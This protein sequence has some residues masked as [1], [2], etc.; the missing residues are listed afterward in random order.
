M[1]IVKERIKTGVVVPAAGFGSRMGAAIPKQFLELAGEPILLRTLR[2]FLN[3]PAT[4][5]VVVVLPPEHLRSSQAMLLFDPAC[6][7]KLIFAAGG[8]TRQQSVRNGLAALPAEIG[9]ILV[10]DGAR[11]LVTTDMID[12]CLKGI[13]QHGA[14]IAAV[15]V[16][17]T[18]KEI[19]GETV[20]RTVDRK[21]LWQAQTPQ[22]MKRHLLEQAYREAERSG[23]T[24]TDE[25]SLLE[26]AGIP[27]A[28]VMGSEQNIK[29]TRPDDLRIAAG[30]LR[31]EANTMLR[32]G[33]GFDAHRL[34][35]GRRLI[36]GGQEILYHLGLD[37]HSDA[38]VLVHALMDAILGALGAGDIG[39]HFPDTDER[40]RG[41][42][43]LRLLAHLMELAWEKQM[44]LV[45][46][47][48]T[49]ICQ[50]P[51]LAPYMTAMKE[52]IAAACAV[53]VEQLN[54]KATTTEGMGYTGRGEGISTHAVVLMAK[55]AAE[56]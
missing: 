5:V 48:I 29:I 51:K 35:E 4:F 19:D 16:K 37:G 27:V 28:V 41:A 40:Y 9:Q 3:H 18:L 54:I 52:S 46:A 49:V 17:D 7:E 44:R 13:E 2:V 32:I 53:S 36:L 50:R 11:P 25:A 20:L 26:H 56:V 43:S 6:C 39:R 31:E 45:N 33:H 15:P 8:A 12:R 55:R 22:G 47:D 24:G 34:V 1:Q 30:L 10:H 38:D 23:F 42:D 14:V 21:R